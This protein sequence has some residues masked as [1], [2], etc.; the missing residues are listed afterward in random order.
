MCQGQQ[1]YHGE[2]DRKNSLFC[3][4]GENAIPWTG[5]SGA[6]SN[7]KSG[8]IPANFAGEAGNKRS[9]KRALTLN[10]VYINGR[11]R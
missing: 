5:R 1:Y 8:Q 4:A 9:K 10:S 2:E 7:L 6:G 11:N 3:I